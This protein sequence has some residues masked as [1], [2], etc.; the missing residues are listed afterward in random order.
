MFICRHCGLA[1]SVV[2]R[3]KSIVVRNS[4]SALRVPRWEHPVAV[5]KH[6]LEVV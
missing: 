6:L 2:A 1:V 5:V 3:V 4:V